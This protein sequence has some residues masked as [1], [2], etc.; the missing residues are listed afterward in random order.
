M[1]AVFNRIELMNALSFAGRI[2]PTRTPK[3]ILANALLAI[4]SDGCWIMASDLEVGCRVRLTGVDVE[5]PGSSIVPIGRVLTVLHPSTDDL[6]EL[7]EP[8]GRFK[9][10]SGRCKMSCATE[11]F[12]NFPAVPE[13]PATG[14]ITIHS[15]HLKLAIQRT[16]VS[17]ASDGGSAGSRFATRGVNIRT[18]K[19]KLVFEATDGR[20]AA[21]MPIAVEGL[22]GEARSVVIPIKV[23]SLLSKEA[24]DGDINISWDEKHVG[25]AADGWQVVSRILDGRF[26]DFD[27]AIPA[28][29]NQKAQI[30]VGRMLSM[31]RQVSAVGNEVTNGATFSVDENTMKIEAEKTELGDSVA[32]S[33]CQSDSVAWHTRLDLRYVTRG[34]AAMD[35]DKTVS[36]ETA[37]ADSPAV[38]TTDDG[39]MF[40]QAV[41]GE[42]K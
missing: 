15:A 37:D 32:E 19:G 6:A 39:Y 23:A 11:D 12:K 34:L 31:V 36:F 22:N 25:F 13:P 27:G 26:P 3:P 8:E 2:A 30:E 17:C 20:S 29:R 9:V 38:F 24:P 7:S 10:V 21:R 4:D 5:S 1:K 16:I 14:V 41:L 28:R 42:T 33:V 35:P 40:V 18:E